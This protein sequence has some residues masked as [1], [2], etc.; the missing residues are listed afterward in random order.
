MQDMYEDRK[1]QGISL[2]VD[3][4]DE[5]E[6]DDGPPQKGDPFYES[7][8]N[9]NLIG[10]A[11][12]FLD[13]LFYDVKL[14][15]Q[16][17]IISQQG[18]VAGKLHMEISKLGSGI[19][20]RYADINDDSD[21]EEG[22]EDDADQSMSVKICEAKGLPK[23]LSNFVFCQ[24]SFWG[25]DD[26]ISV[27]PEIHPDTS[28]KDNV[29]RSNSLV[30]R[31]HEVTRKIE[32]WIEI[33]EVNDQGEYAPVEVKP[34]ADVPAAGVFQLRQGHARRILTRIKSRGDSGTLPLICDSISS[35]A[36]GCI[37]ARS[38]I[39][40]GLDSYQEEDLGHLRDRWND[41]LSR[42]HKYLDSQIQ[43]L[44]NKTD[45]TEADCDRESAL[46]DQWVSLTEERNAVMVPVAGSE[47]PGAPADWEAPPD[48]EQH[49]PVLFLDL[50]CVCHCIL[51]FFNP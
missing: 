16:V 23:D 51:G 19:M 45:K 31:W 37:C 3:D 27:P 38:K 33:H 20:D 22:N 41:A 9:H 39:Q 4:S 14:D 25:H 49:R 5:S 40:K 29:A 50:N 34:Q 8:E 35:L 24:Y 7:Y 18:E 44:I 21:N 42:R 36:I 17:P 28:K 43:S 26:P 30:D 6:S 15:Y 46:I 48:M 32:L 12:V 13:C 1:S 47:I 11:N 10:V 2:R